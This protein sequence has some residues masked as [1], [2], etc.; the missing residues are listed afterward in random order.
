MVTK[1][2]FGW[3]SITR[4]EMLA[5]NKKGD[6]T[7]VRPPLLCRTTPGR[8]RTCDLRFRKPSLYP[9]SYGGKVVSGYYV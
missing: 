5:Q 6:F 2:L 4:R 1:T 3:R 8:D 7:S 9:L